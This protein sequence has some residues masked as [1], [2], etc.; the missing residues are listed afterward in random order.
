MLLHEVII[1]LVNLQVENSA[2]DLE[3]VL[4]NV[5]IFNSVLLEIGLDKNILL[6][7]IHEIEDFSSSLEGHI[8]VDQMKFSQNVNEVDVT[9]HIFASNKNILI[10]L[11]KLSNFGVVAF[12]WSRNDYWICV[13]G[14]FVEQVL[15]FLKE[16]FV[17]GL[18]SLK[19]IHGIIA[20]LLQFLL[21]LGIDFLLDIFPFIALAVVLR[22][23]INV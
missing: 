23:E 15:S 17:L 20:D 8:A 11:V 21:I 12:L 2:N 22:L 9:N 10:L 14:R 13:D 19:L 16:S 7:S 3:Q 5:I 4:L 18:E 6:R 1:S